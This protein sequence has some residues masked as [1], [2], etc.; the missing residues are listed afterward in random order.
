MNI[1]NNNRNKANKIYHNKTIKYLII[2]N[3]NN[4]NNNC[5]K[6]HLNHRLNRNYYQHHHNLNKKYNK[7]IKVLIRIAFLKKIFFKKD[8]ISLNKSLL[9]VM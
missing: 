1:N 9:N 2:R 5:N 3:N 6:Y 4:N 7:T 8:W